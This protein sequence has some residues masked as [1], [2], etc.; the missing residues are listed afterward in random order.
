MNK[1]DKHS[2]PGWVS[3]CREACFSTARARKVACR[4]VGRT[5]WEP[6]PADFPG[7]GNHV[8]VCG[9]GGLPSPSSLLSRVT[10]AGQR[11]S[12]WDGL[13][14]DG[15]NCHVLG[16]VVPGNSAVFAFAALASWVKNGSF[17]TAWAV[18]PLSSC[19]CSY[20]YGRGTAIGP[21]TGERC[22]PLLDKLWRAIAP[23]M[24][25]WCAEGD[26]PT[27]ANLNLY[28]DGLRM[29]DGT[30]MMNRCSVRFMMVLWFSLFKA[31][32]ASLSS[33]VNLRRNCRQKNSKTSF[34]PKKVFLFSRNSSKRFWGMILWYLWIGRAKNHEPANVGGW[35]TPW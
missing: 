3:C 9:Y 26:V 13:V 10:W 1:A 5:Q 23:L 27:A 34:S 24:K 12:E 29:W 8:G 21:Q 25:P 20:L 28:R 33:R 4:D 16:L 6:Q 19:S 32:Y 15:E 35:L 7:G 18:P 11:S 30:A 31:V 14:T 17:L 2:V 22:W